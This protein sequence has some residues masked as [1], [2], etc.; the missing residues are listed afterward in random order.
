MA[1][2]IFY[3]PFVVLC[4]LLLWLLCSVR[5][6]QPGEP[7]L[8]NGWIPYLGVALEYG[9]NPL[10]FLRSMQRKYGDIFTCKIA[11]SYFTFVLDPFSYGAVSRQGRNLDFQKFAIGFSHKVFGH[12]DFNDPVYSY[13]IKDIHSIFRQTLQGPVLQQLIS[14]MMENLQ[15][16]MRRDEGHGWTTEGLQVFV[17]RIMFEA[18]YLTLFGKEEEAEAMATGGA[19]P[20]WLFMRQAME[21]FHAFD[22]AFP[23]MAAGLPIHLCGR[24][25]RAREALAEKLH[26]RHLKRNKCLS[27]LIE[28]RMH[29][30]DQMEQLDEKEKARTHVSMLWASQANT[31]PA[32]FWSLYYILRC[33][34]ALDAAQAE[35]RRV[36]GESGHTPGNLEK[37]VVLSKDQLAGMSVLGSIIEE[38]LRLSSASIMIRVA[39]ENFT[40]TLDTGKTAAIRKGDHIAMFPQMMHMDPEIYEDPTEFQCS[41]FLDENGQ[42]KTDF[43]KNGRKLRQFLLP[44]GSGVSECP[45]RFFAINEIKQFLT[46][47]LCHYDM[48]LHDLAAAPLE[49][50]C[51]RAGLGI[52][53]PKHDVSLRYRFRNCVT[54]KEKTVR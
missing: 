38:A 46:L 2:L 22:K 13:N 43:Y 12:A 44:F 19:T 53:P 39:S 1:A 11:G 17:E 33:P 36:L 16:V 6:R 54:V 8:M 26:H 23:E 47:A 30:F 45:G 20:R 27:A 29:A 4:A 52:L 21:D 41:R 7:P 18:G 25:F 5:R 49:T 10:E 37:P 31:L 9:R 35:V 40:L 15:A 3:A 32:T 34:V 48:E 28:R 50:D 51:T 24:A 42:K 14:T